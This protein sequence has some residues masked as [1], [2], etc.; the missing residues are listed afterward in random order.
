MLRGGRLGV[1]LC[2]IGA[3]LNALIG[4]WQ[5]RIPQQAAG[6]RPQ[7]TGRR[8]AMRASLCGSAAELMAVP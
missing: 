3:G 6:H 7:V 2:D 1:L 8:S 4:V 5:A